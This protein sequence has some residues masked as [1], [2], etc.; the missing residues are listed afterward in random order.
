MNF[1]VERKFRIPDEATFRARASR[2]G[3]LF[4]PPSTQIDTYYAHP[5]RNFADTDEAL[6]I[7]RVEGRC[8]IT[9]KGPKTDET[10]KTRQELDISIGSI[11]AEGRQFDAL[12][13]AL[14]FHEVMSVKKL[15]EEALFMQA[16]RDYSVCL[17]LAEGL[18]WFVEIETIAEE[19][20]VPAALNALD[21]L[22]SQLQLTDNER[23]SY[24][25]LKLEA[26]VWE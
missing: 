8:S 14:G 12:L 4:G 18:G 20:D 9:Y 21:S 17:D 15:R 10:S 1:E 16:D 23:R 25:E 13:L 22:A 6:R 2:L 3:I 7:R 5:S 26:A 19:A 24:L 11:D